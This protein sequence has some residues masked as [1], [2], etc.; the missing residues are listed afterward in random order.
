[1]IYTMKNVI[2]KTYSCFE[3][4]GQFVT[5]KKNQVYI[6]ELISLAKTIYF[7]AYQVS[8]PI[9]YKKWSHVF[10]FLSVVT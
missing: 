7:S 10:S 6:L 5:L 4:I 9:L 1:M 3:K 2:F 8:Q